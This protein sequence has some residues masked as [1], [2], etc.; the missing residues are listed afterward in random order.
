[1]VALTAG[2]LLWLGKRDIAPPYWTSFREKVFFT[3]ACLVAECLNL[4]CARWESFHWALVGAVFAGC[5][6]AA[7]AMDLAEHMIYRYV[8]L[9]CGIAIMCFELAEFW[10]ANGDLLVHVVQAGQW[11]DWFVFVALQQFLFAQMYGRADCHAFCCCGAMWI[12]EGGGFALCVLHMAISFILLTVV[13]LGRRNITKK[14]RLKRAVPML[15]YITAGFWIC[16][17]GVNWP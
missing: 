11:R 2:F 15:P 13:Q 16:R 7:C 8:W 12:V 14:G 1:M 9:V 17:L 3:V 6:I 5:L 4:W 10:G